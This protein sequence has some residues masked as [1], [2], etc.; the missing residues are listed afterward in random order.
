MK[1]YQ[2]IKEIVEQ[3][4]MSDYECEGG[5]LKNNVAFIR[6]QEMAELNYQPKFQLNE[7]VMYQDKPY[8]VRG[9]VSASASHPYPDVEYSL[10]VNQNRECTTNK[11]DVEG[12]KE[13]SLMTVAE[14]DKLQVD[15]AIKFLES[16]G[17]KVS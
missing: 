13:N 1:K 17:K 3:L 16:K 4:S 6:L 15:N 10:S 5:F 2:T 12:V 11:T 7:P 9:M 14:W 8:F